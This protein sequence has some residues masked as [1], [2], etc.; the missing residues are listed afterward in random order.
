M[1]ELS[2]SM[3]PFGEIAIFLMVNSPFSSAGYRSLDL[4]GFLFSDGYH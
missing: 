1:V 2:I 3:G 4:V